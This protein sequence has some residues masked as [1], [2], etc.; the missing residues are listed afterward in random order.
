MNPDTSTL[1]ATG[2]ASDIPKFFEGLSE[3][4]YVLRWNDSYEGAPCTHYAVYKSPPIQ[5]EDLVKTY[6]LSGKHYK[7]MDSEELEISTLKVQFDH[8]FSKDARV[9]DCLWLGGG[10]LESVFIEWQTQFHD[11]EL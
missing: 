3:L 11:D 4:R 8:V 5:V 6:D 1:P 10:L 2:D 7:L 9:V